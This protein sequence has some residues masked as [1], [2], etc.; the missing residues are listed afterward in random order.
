MSAEQ[1]QR[2]LTASR[3]WLRSDCLDTSWYI[4][5]ASWSYTHTH[6]QTTHRVIDCLEVVVMTDRHRDRDRDTQ[7][8]RDRERE[9][10]RERERDRVHGDWP[11]FDQPCW[12]SPQPHHERR[13][14][15]TALMDHQ[16]TELDDT[17]SHICQTQRSN[18]DWTKP[19]NM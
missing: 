14:T 7:T 18:V 1:Q 10:E 9:R 6:R 15:W 3:N 8:Q 19:L 5:V 12:H 11:V 4:Y 16:Q 17:L 13:P 2:G